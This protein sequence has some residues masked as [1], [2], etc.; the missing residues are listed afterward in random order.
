MSRKSDAKKARRR[1]RQA[2]RAL[3]FSPDDVQE[4]VAEV[5]ADLEGFD[6]QLTE[7]G[8]VFSEDTDDDTGV[9]W[10]WPPSYAEVADPD[11]ATA[12]VV[13]LIEAE[14]GDIAHV[15]FVGADEDY[16]FGLDEIFEHIEV[17]ESYR[18]GEPLP[19]FD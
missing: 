9:L 12:T 1:K 15:V 18:A 16:Q 10:F 11:M 19:V 7:R 8:W 5:V 14:G 4:R 6:A 13:A 2:A 17:I 3:A